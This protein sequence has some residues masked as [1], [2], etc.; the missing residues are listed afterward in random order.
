[1]KKTVLVS[2][3]LAL[4]F[5]VAGS[6]IAVVRTRYAAMFYL[7]IFAYIIVAAYKMGMV[8]EKPRVVRRHDLTD[9]AAA[10]TEPAEIEPGSVIEIRDDN[11]GN[12]PPA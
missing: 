10:P 4:F 5:A 12:Q 7:I 6:L 9:G 8:H 1:V 11:T 3:G 2:Y